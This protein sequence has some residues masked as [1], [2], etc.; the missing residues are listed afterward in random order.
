MVEVFRLVFCLDGIFMGGV[1]QHVL[2]TPVTPGSVQCV[3]GAVAKFGIFFIYQ[4][5]FLKFAHNM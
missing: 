1:T 2:G 5:I 4:P 3:E